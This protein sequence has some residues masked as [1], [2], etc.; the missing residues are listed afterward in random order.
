MR[1]MRNP[2]IPKRMGSE[3]LFKRTE[4]LLG[5]EAMDAL[6]RTRVIVFGV[7]GVGGWCA[8]ALARSGVGHLTLVDSDCVAVSNVNR[9]LMATTK[10]V[11]QPKTEAL[12]ARLLEIN[13]AADVT[14]RTE[15]YTPE[16]ADTFDLAQYDY[17][18]DAI[19]S[20]DCKAHLIRHALSIPSVT[21][22][23]SMGAACKFDP[24]RIRTSEFWKVEGDG[25]ARALRNRFRRE[26]SFPARKFICVWSDERMENRGAATAADGRANGTVMHVTATFGLA[27][28]SL[29]LRSS[30]QRR[31]DRPPAAAS[32]ASTPS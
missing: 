15:R 13:P 5:A 22:F 23:A 7:G 19:D 24:L 21:L 8:E 10:T 1:G 32:A 14:V 4:L 11:G 30:S 20:V 26:Q 25:L 12:C 27:L 31:P 9:Q 29:V 6:A 2:D 3:D 18:I 16:T 28:A 17:V